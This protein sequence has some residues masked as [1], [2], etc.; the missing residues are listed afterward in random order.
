MKDEHKVIGQG[1]FLEIKL[2]SKNEKRYACKEWNVKRIQE[3]EEFEK[4]ELRK[5]ILTHEN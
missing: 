2:F 5:M 4:E 3:E 1:G